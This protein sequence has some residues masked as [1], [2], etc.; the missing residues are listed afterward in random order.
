[1]FQRFSTLLNNC[2]RVTPGVWQTLIF[3]L[4]PFLIV[5]EN[6]VVLAF[7]NNSWIQ[8]NEMLLSK[9]GELIGSLPDRWIEGWILCYSKTGQQACKFWSWLKSLLPVHNLQGTGPKWPQYTEN[10]SVK[11]VSFDSLLQLVW[12]WL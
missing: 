2:R 1:M 8:V 7:V 12:R 3:W 10:Y 4:Q 9:H 6:A 5:V 11:T